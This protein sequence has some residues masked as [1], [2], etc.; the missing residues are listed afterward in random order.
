MENK[1]QNFKIN[2]KN[3]VASTLHTDTVIIC[4]SLPLQIGKGLMAS[5]NSII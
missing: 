2:L 5:P 4:G 1:N 3:T